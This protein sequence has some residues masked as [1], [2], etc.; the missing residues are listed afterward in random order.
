[1]PLMCKECV[2]GGECVEVFGDD[3][4]VY[5]NVCVYLTQCLDDM[6]DRNCE[7]VYLCQPPIAEVFLNSCT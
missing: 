3:W 2:A 4:L 6:D 1:M 7:E 5:D